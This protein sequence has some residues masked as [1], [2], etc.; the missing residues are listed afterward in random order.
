MTI[1]ITLIGVFNLARNIMAVFGTVAFLFLAYKFVGGFI[2]AHRKG[3]KKAGLCCDK[4]IGK[5]L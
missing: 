4:A 1:E 5:F 3:K 2:E